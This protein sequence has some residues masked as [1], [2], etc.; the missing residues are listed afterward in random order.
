MIALCRPWGEIK[1]A[2]DK[3][4]FWLSKRGVIWLGKLCLTSLIE[5][6][7]AAARAGDK[8]QSNAHGRLFFDLLGA[9]SMDDKL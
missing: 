7:K 2:L 3:K 4:S 6:K 9:S 1:A 8:S 5:Q